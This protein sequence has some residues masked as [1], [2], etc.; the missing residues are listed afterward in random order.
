[1]QQ[2]ELII[3]DMD[4]VLADTTQCHDKA[5]LDLWSKIG[6]LGPQY[7][8]IAGRKTREVVEEYTAKLKPSPSQILNWVILKQLQARKYLSSEEIIYSDSGYCLK[9]LAISGINMALA[10]A[11][12]YETAKIILNRLGDIDLFSII[13]TAEDVKNGK[14]SPEIYLNV[15]TKAKIIPD[16]TLIIEDSLS[17]LKAAIES[18]AFVASVRSGKAIQGPKFVGNFSDLRELLLKLEIVQ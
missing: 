18:K 16:K 1:M 5:Y 8:I 15:M 10:T 9:A 4:G 7:E 14:P 13:A 6:I 12:S 11:A 3:F 2:F 17:G